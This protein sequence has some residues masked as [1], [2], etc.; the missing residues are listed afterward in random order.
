MQYYFNACYIGYWITHFIGKKDNIQSIPDSRYNGL[1]RRS[2]ETGPDLIYF[3][4]HKKL[5]S[6]VAENATTTILWVFVNILQSTVS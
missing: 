1:L 3:L 2:N 5:Y 4:Y 6:C